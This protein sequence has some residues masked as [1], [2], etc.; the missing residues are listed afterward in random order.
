[1]NVKRYP[2]AVYLV[3]MAMTF[4]LIISLVNN[5]SLDTS[6]K[7]ED[8]L[9]RF[10]SY[11]ELVNFVNSRHDN[12]LPEYL[13]GLRTAIPEAASDQM[14][15]YGYSQ[16][17]VQVKGI[18]ESDIIKTDGE[19]IYFVNR[20]LISII[21]AYPPESLEITSEI[22]LNGYYIEGLYVSKVYNLLIVIGNRY[23]YIGIPIVRGDSQS[24]PASKLMAPETLGA[25]LSSILIYD[26]SDP[27]DPKKLLNISLFGSIYQSRLYKSVLYINNVQ[28]VHNY[29]YKSNSIEVR[30]P[31]IWI[32][33]VKEEIYP[34]NIKYIPGLYDNSLAY[35]III[36]LDLSTLDF[37][38]EVFLLGYTGVLYMS[39][40]NI[41]IAQ[42]IYPPMI[43]PGDETIKT[44][45]DV[46][47]RIY[48]FSVDGLDIKLQA[49]GDVKGSI[50][51][52]FQLDEYMGL[53]RVSTHSWIITR[54]SILRYTNIFILDDKL[55]VIGSI[56]GLAESEML[57]ATRFMGNYAYLVT[58][59]LVD[60]LFIINL[61][62]PT[63]PYVEGELK[64]PGFSTYLHPVSDTLLVGIGYETDNTTRI[65][66]LKVSLFDVSDPSKPKEVDNIVFN[67]SNWV[68]SEAL[69]NHKAILV[70]SSRNMIGFSL[71]FYDYTPYPK[72][73]VQYVLIEVTTD[74]LNLIRS[75]D[76]SPD[77]LGYYEPGLV[78]GV[79]IDTYL[80]I[81]SNN[82]V[83]VYNLEDFSLVTMLIP[84]G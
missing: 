75:L 50:S 56:E 32:N 26:V 30:L 12:Y 44:S 73:I 17:N 52:Q 79:Y 69:Y 71:I 72:N 21:K 58:F 66:G 46:T 24:S 18:D 74:G 6:N 10:R 35:N 23:G 59:R 82:G 15:S 63:N 45:N 55:N 78:R 68:W 39:Y 5:F 13:L 40:D 57:Y 11:Y 29:D 51:S 48:K 81:V 33:G 76:L 62:D 60:P 41:Y 25:P 1:M 34:S 43:L 65:V 9:P 31:E 37:S 80:Y 4:L 42:T 67:I 8:S 27:S 28:S 20:S 53:L 54:D 77:S 84:Y 70:M 47:T 16:T 61:E 36:A 19:Y 49:I 3:I 38:Y 83:M 7:E 64:I 2:P 14:N 22:N